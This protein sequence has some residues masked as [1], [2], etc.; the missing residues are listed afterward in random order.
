MEG[1][2]QALSILNEYG[3]S[4][5]RVWQEYGWSMVR[6]WLEANILF[7]RWEQNIPTLGTKHSQPGNKT[8]LRLVIM[9]LL[10]VVGATGAW[11]QVTDYSG[12]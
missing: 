7:P 9:L 3:K 8:S 5:L 1:S 6:V 2:K 4:K 12:V 11:G 10:M